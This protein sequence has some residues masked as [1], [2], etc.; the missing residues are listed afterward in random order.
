MNEFFLLL[1][2]LGHLFFGQVFFLFLFIYHVQTILLAVFTVSPKSENWGCVLETTPEST[3]PVWMPTL[4]SICWWNMRF[5]RRAFSH[6]I[7]N[8]FLSCTQLGKNKRVTSWQSSYALSCWKMK[9]L[10]K[11]LHKQM[12]LRATSAHIYRQDTHNKRLVFDVIERKN[13]L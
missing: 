4:K 11:N 8:F 5:D 2:F 3:D 12:T 13:T 7:F 6:I 10:K 9:N 1:F